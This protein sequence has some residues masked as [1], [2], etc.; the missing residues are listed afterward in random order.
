MKDGHLNKCKE[1]TK[2][3]SINHRKDN[4]DY[5]RKYDNERAQLP[6][7][8]ELNTKTT[9]RRR[10]ENPLMNRAH[11]KV[12]HAVKSGKLK[13]PNE[14]M[15]CRNTT[16]KLMGHH[17]DYNKPLEVWWLC[18]PCHKKRHK[19]IDSGIINPLF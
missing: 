3:D 16:S 5:Y 10:H 14:C 11:L 7:R 17:E 4:I 18:Q 12:Q 13:K 19:E 2:K 8:K 1:C 6:H 9:K 15:W